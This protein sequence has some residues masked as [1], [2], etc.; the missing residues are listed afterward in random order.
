VIALYAK[1]AYVEEVPRGTVAVAAMADW[2]PKAAIVRNAIP[3]T[4]RVPKE[5]RRD[6]RTPPRSR[7]G[8]VECDVL[9]EEE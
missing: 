5:S 2:V 4:D 9:G 8:R 3:V 1:T 6:R 7:R